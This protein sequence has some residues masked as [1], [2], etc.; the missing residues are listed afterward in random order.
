MKW[1]DEKIEYYR[2]RLYKN[3]RDDFDGLLNDALAALDE[4][5][6]RDELEAEISRADDHLELIAEISSGFSPRRKNERLT[7]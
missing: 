3:D 6:I 2:S 1:A 4:D 7:A 5:E